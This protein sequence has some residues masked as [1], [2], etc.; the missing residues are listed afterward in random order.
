M[1]VRIGQVVRFDN[2]NYRYRIVDVDPEEGL[3][4]IQVAKERVGD[5]EWEAVKN[6]KVQ[7]GWFS[8]EN[9]R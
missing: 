7:A 5:Y 9:I 4:R 8:V 3:V 2:P 6:G 1:K